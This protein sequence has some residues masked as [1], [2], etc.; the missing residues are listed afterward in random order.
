MSWNATEM[1]RNEKNICNNYDRSM[2]L[3]ANFQKLLLQINVKRQ[4]YQ[5]E[6]GKNCKQAIHRSLESQKVL[7]KKKK[8]VQPS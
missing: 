8:D 2:F 5:Q 6:M 4:A 1:F 7:G 3:L